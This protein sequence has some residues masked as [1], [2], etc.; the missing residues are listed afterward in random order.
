MKILVIDDE[1]SIR[2]SLTLGLKKLNATLFSAENG[3]DGLAIFKTQSIDLVIL[4][5]KLPDIS[6]IEVLKLMKQQNENC[7]VIMMTHLSEVKLAVQ[8]MKLGAHDYFTK[9]F[10]IEEMLNAIKQLD[11]Y[12]R[13]KAL[14]SQ[15]SENPNQMVGK[16]DAIT[17]IVAKLKKLSKI[18]FSTCVLINGES[19]TGKELVAKQIHSICKPDKPF[20]A[21][22]C[23]AIP[24]HLQESELF[25]HEMGAFS[26]AKKQR[27]GLL[28]YAE[29]GVLFLDEIGDM[30]I[31][32]QAKLLRVLQ[33][34]TYRRIGGNYEITFNAMVI[35]ATNKDLISEVEANTF[36]KDLFYRLNI[37]PIRVPPLRE[38]KEDIPILIE[39]FIQIYN[40]LLGKNV[41][42][43]SED[44][45]ELFYKYSWPGNIRELKN[46]IERLMILSDSD[47]LFMEELPYELTDDDPRGKGQFS[48]LEQAEHEAVLRALSQYNWNITK[49][50]EALQI[51]RLTLRRKI[52]KYGISN[53]S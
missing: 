53:H 5:I 50:A 13:E 27:I 19:G 17:T 20:V 25:G 51:S 23:A 31:D 42:G 6:G 29:N 38:R 40:Q 3:M 7:T 32:L 46:I 44:M 30:D 2:V 37:I 22:N 8:A 35:A 21:I 52:D 41:K 47:I 9:P 49:A 12:I 48:H 36:R 28:E 14:I 33:E 11:F 39:H 43:L 4:D 26:D 24:K 18:Q 1:K 45:L 34:K 16:S 15:S 10:S